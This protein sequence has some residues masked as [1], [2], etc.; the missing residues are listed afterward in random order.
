MV[1]TSSK[2]LFLMVVICFWCCF[3][4]NKLIITTWSAR[5][6]IHLLQTFYNRIVVTPIIPAYSQ[7]LR[8]HNLGYSTFIVLKVLK[9]FDYSYITLYTWSTLSSQPKLFPRKLEQKIMTSCPGH[10]S[11]SSDGK[12]FRL[13]IWR[14]Q[15]QIPQWSKLSDFNHS[16]NFLA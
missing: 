3:E 8:T 14:S 5:W 7:L 11:D 2:V 10:G 15:A 6:D 12:A 1:S 4:Y 9:F 16:F 13:L